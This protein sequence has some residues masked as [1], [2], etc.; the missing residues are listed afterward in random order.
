MGAVASGPTGGVCD[1]RGRELWLAA[2]PRLV[3]LAKTSLENEPNHLAHP[4]HTHV[5]KKLEPWR[6]ARH[7]PAAACNLNGSRVGE[8]TEFLDRDAARRAEAAWRRRT[9]DRVPG[10]PVEVQGKRD[11]ALTGSTESV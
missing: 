2:R 3:Y 5:R 7:D 8:L 11:R 1:R 10:K 6:A 4:P 9:L